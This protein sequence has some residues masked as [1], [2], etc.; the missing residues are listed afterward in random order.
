[1]QTLAR[2]RALI[3]TADANTQGQTS[4]TAG[5]FYRL[6]TDQLNAGTLGQPGSQAGANATV[7]KPANSQPTNAATGNVNLSDFINNV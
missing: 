4:G 1:L 6:I 3:G 7:F 5:D 2:Q